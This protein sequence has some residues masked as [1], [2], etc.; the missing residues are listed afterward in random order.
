MHIITNHILLELEDTIKTHKAEQVKKEVEDKEKKDGEN[1]QD[2]SA[3]LN[4][5]SP[6]IEK[7]AGHY[8]EHYRKPPQNEMSYGAGN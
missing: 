2:D 3:D 1:D 5:A 8:V 7:A 4:F 6:H